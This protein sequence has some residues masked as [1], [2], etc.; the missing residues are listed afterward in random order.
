MYLDTDVILAELKDD[1]WLAS[2]VN[3]EEIDDPK[4]S[5]ATCIEIHYV[6]EDEWGRDR[7]SKAFFEIKT[8]GVHFVPL[9]MYHIASGGYLLREYER[10]NVFDASIWVRRVCWKRQ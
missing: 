2:A 7:V 5:V 6:M 8:L 4:T 9:E 3:I 10:L 1:D